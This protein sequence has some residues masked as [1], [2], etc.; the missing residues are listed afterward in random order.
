MQ[1]VGLLTGGIYFKMYQ[2][3]LKD[4]DIRML[5]EPGQVFRIA[6]CGQ[7]CYTVNS[8]RSFRMP[9]L[10]RASGCGLWERWGFCGIFLH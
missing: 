8:R 6:P 3:I 1:A 2:T 7:D 9:A 5:M 4:F 10:C